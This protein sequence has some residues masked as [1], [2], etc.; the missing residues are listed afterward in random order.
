MW[1]PDSIDLIKKYFC[2]AQRFPLLHYSAMDLNKW[3]SSLKIYK[4]YNCR[5]SFNIFRIYLFDS[6]FNCQLHFTLLYLFV[7]ML[8]HLL[9]NFLILIKYLLQKKCTEL[10]YI[11]RSTC[12]CL[13]IGLTFRLVIFWSISIFII[14]LFWILIFKFLQG[15][16]VGLI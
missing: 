11:T 16:I 4:V 1:A 8:P 3:N 12:L 6:I 5:I 7:S 9:F 13:F 15:Y 10:K 2:G 14:I